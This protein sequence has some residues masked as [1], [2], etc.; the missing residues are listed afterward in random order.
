MLVTGDY[1]QGV[2]MGLTAW[3]CLCVCGCSNRHYHVETDLCAE[4]LDGSRINPMRHG[5]PA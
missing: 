4:C 3:P 5:E 1:R 2:S